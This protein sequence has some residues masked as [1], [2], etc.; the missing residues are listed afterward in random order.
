MDLARALAAGTASD[1][2]AGEED[3]AAGEAGTSTKDAGS[4]GNM[5]A[6]DAIKAAID[7][8]KKMPGIDD[9][10]VRR[11]VNAIDCVADLTD[12]SQEQLTPLIGP[13]NAKKL[14]T[15]LRSPFT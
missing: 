4:A 2:A 6:E 1:A 3:G 5:P 14:Y 15:F 9:K 10:N 13:V 7:M 8:M 12:M 11:I